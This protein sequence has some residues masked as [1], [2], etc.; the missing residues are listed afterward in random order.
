MIL[1]TSYATVVLAD[2]TV[3][4]A[5]NTVV[6]TIATVVLTIT[7][8]ILAITT[9]VLATATVVLTITTVVL[10]ITTVVLTITTVVLAITTAVSAI[11]RCYLCIYHNSDCECLLSKWYV[12]DI[13]QSLYR[14]IF[15]V[16]VYQCFKFSCTMICVSRNFG[17]IMYIV[18]GNLGTGILAMP[19]AFANAGILVGTWLCSS[20]HIL[21][22]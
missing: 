2:N 11:N 19:Y 22:I 5:I 21:S 13:V 4:L 6:L 10:T 18:K 14:Y 7:T 16:E 9:V 20:L 15:D 8:V 1:C 12:F 3:V 17:T